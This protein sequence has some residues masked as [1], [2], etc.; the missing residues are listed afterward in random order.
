[1]LA[2]MAAVEMSVKH[3]VVFPSR[4]YTDVTLS[5]GWAVEI[6]CFPVHLQSGC[7]LAQTLDIE[8]KVLLRQLVTV[9]SVIPELLLRQIATTILA[10]TGSLEELTDSC[11]AQQLRISWA[12]ARKYDYMSIILPCKYETAQ[13]A[14]SSFLNDSGLHDRIV[15]W[16]RM[17]LKVM[18]AAEIPY[19]LMSRDSLLPLI[20]GRSLIA[21]YALW[22]SLRF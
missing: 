14:L 8:P 22:A 1:M 15:P 16:V 7:C 2:F 10:E 21:C 12:Y 3:T 18:S 9:V 4:Y 20:L 11:L 17:P 5:S 13:S 6:V 19:T